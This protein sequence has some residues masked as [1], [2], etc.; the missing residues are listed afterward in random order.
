MCFTIIASLHCS[1]RGNAWSRDRFAS[2]LIVSR[3]ILEGTNAAGGGRR[4]DTATQPR[5]IAQPAS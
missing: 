2:E 4:A 5:E 1:S 3:S